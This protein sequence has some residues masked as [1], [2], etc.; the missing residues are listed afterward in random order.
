MHTITVNHTT[1][2][3]TTTIATTCCCLFSIDITFSTTFKWTQGFF[4]WTRVACSAWACVG[5]G[6]VLSC[7][8]WS[9]GAAKSPAQCPTLT[10]YAFSIADGTLTSAVKVISTSEDVTRPPALVSDALHHCM[11]NDPRLN[12]IVSTIDTNCSGWA[13]FFSFWA[14]RLWSG[15]GAGVC[16]RKPDGRCNEKILKSDSLGY[17]YACFPGTSSL[18]PFFCFS[19]SWVDLDWFFRY[20]SSHGSCPVY[21]LPSLWSWNLWRSFAHLL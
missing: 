14:L 20:N 19:C 13:P 10:S 12:L 16:E 4:F 8:G 11:E 1:A 2:T 18:V 6:F 5:P 17:R 7:V 21:A 9:S 3:S 15:E